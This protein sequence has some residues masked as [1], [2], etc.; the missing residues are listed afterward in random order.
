MGRTTLDR[1]WT[2]AEIDAADSIVAMLAAHSRALPC[3]VL[4]LI[5]GLGMPYRT[6]RD[7]RRGKARVQDLMPL[8]VGRCTATQPGYVPV[9]ERDQ[10][11][12]VYY[13]ADVTDPV[14][15]ARLRKL[16]GQR[17]KSVHTKITRAR[18][19]LRDLS[20]CGEFGDRV[21]SNQ[22]QMALL[23]LNPALLDEAIAQA[24]GIAALMGGDEE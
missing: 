3:G 12:T 8:V 7:R 20:L 2:Q 9:W 14:Q 21:M 22:V 19:E 13:L 1:Q 10:H 4:P 15:V 11:G 6:T 24:E 5:R 17:L 23:A 16:T 18:D